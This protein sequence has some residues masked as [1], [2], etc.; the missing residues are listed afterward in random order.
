MRYEIFLYHGKLFIDLANLCQID[1]LVVI[2]HL[3]ASNT[4]KEDH[5]SAAA[6]PFGS[7]L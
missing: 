2:A 3:N 4:T 7:I 1:W 5:S 6:L